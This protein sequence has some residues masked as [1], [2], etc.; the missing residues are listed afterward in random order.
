MKRLLQRLLAWI[1]VVTT[2]GR[3]QRIEK[4]TAERHYAGRQQGREKHERELAKA[5]E[6]ARRVIDRCHHIRFDR[7]SDQRY[8]VAIAFDVRMMAGLSYGHD[9]EFIARHIGQQVEAEIATARFIQSAAQ[10]EHDRRVSGERAALRAAVL[11]TRKNEIV[12]L[13]A[14]ILKACKASERETDASH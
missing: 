12:A 7:G 11:K 1:P 14:A 10:S 3:I 13:R 8:T 9:L 5:T 2:R 6:F 4:R